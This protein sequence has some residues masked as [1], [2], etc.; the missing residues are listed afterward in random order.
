ML[1]R[2]T[3]KTVQ[4]KIFRSAH[5]SYKKSV[6]YRVTTFWFLFIPVYSYSEF[7]N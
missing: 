5:D 7:L 6:L 1:I 4:K 2:K 3:S